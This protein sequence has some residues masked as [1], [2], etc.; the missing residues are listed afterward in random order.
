MIDTRP[1]GI[2]EAQARRWNAA[3]IR[4]RRTRVRR[5]LELFAVMGAAHAA[6]V[7]MMSHVLGS[8]LGTAMGATA[9]VLTL[10]MVAVTRYQWHEIDADEQ[11]MLA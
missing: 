10:G 2:G 3:T 11:G 9:T 1:P 6:T 7:A 4:D 8:T 5:T